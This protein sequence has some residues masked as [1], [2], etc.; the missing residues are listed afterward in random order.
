MTETSVLELLRS[1]ANSIDALHERGVIR[2]R[3]VVGCYAAHLFA[4]AMRWT[5]ENNASRG[6]DAHDADGLRYQIKA[7]RITRSNTSTQLGDLPA[8][9]VQE[10]DALAEIVFKE[11]FTVLRAAVIPTHALL[12]MR[13]KN[14]ARPRFYL[15]EAVMIAPDVVDVTGALSAAQSELT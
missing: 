6:F 15:R 7:R 11:D 14:A 3:N 5:L 9:D 1:Y 13:T 12:K 8:G 4:R 10:F 2:T